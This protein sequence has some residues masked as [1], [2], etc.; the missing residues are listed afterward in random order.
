MEENVSEESSEDEYDGNISGVVIEF[1]LESELPT[2]FLSKDPDF[3]VTRE[4]AATLIEIQ[5]S[6]VKDQKF[7]V[8]KN[9]STRPDTSSISSKPYNHVIGTE[10]M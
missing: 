9:S 3:F 10:Q 4:P 7:S 5:D 1:E 2:D 6:K 8:S